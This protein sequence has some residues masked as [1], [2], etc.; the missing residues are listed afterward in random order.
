MNITQIVVRDIRNFCHI[1]IAVIECLSDNNRVEAIF[2]D[3]QFRVT[4]LYVCKDGWISALFINKSYDIRN[5]AQ[6]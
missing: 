3:T 1:E 2:I 6:R 5:V 4:W